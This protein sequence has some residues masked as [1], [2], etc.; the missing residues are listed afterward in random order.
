MRYSQGD[1]SLPLDALGRIGWGG[2]LGL[3]IAIFV[4]A[5]MIGLLGYTYIVQRKR[6]RER[7]RDAPPCRKVAERN[8]ADARGTRGGRQARQ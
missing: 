3:C 1:K 5:A 7:S 4:H 8:A 2:R 6:C